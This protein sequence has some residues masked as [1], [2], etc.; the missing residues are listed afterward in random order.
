MTCGIPVR[1]I[2]PAARE[3]PIC[4]YECDKPLVAVEDFKVNSFRDILVVVS[5]CDRDTLEELIVAI[6]CELNP[7]VV[8]AALIFVFVG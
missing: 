1:L 7:L 3:Q 5:N 8:K 4:Y 6:Q 2:L